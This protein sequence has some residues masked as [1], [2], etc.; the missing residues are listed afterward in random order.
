MAR[1][2]ADGD[3]DGGE[4][5]QTAPRDDT[6]A[7]AA[8]RRR[9]P[10]FLA[11]VPLPHRVM[12]PFINRPKLPRVMRQRVTDRL[13]GQ[14]LALEALRLGRLDDAAAV[15]GDEGCRR[16]AVERAVAQEAEVYARS[17]SW[18]VYSNLAARCQ[19]AADDPGGGGAAQADPEIEYRERL[20]NEAAAT[21]NAR[22]AEAQRGRGRGR[23]VKRGLPPPPSPG[24]A[25]AAAAPR[26]AAPLEEDDLNWAAAEPEVDQGAAAAYRRQVRQR[27]ADELAALPAAAALA[28]EERVAV[29]DRCADKVA[30]QYDANGGGARAPAPPSG[31]AL[32]ALVASYVDYVSKARRKKTTTI[33]GRAGCTGPP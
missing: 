11:A 15:A 26:Q 12:A 1:G 20:Q 5:P 31:R 28:P 7:E 2:E 30:L 25:A 33:R 14:H 21:R 9:G 18:Q 8:W 10:E 3:G 27:V 24:T 29:A 16:R 19:A 32:S 6:A 4:E 13:V 23:G 17:A 22:E